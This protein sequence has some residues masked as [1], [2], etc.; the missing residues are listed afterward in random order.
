GDVTAEERTTVLV[1]P[2]ADLPR[3]IHECPALT[4]VLV[5]VMVDRARVFKSSELLDEKM[6]SL[7]RLAAGLAHELNNPASAVARSAKTLGAKLAAFDAVTRQF[8]SL[9]LSEGDFTAVATLRE[10]WN[11]A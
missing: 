6:A 10:R 5:H 4:A 9:N 1:V 8:C 7:G 2:A 11:V 3:L